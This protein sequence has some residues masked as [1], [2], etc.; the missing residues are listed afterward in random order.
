[1]DPN[2][3]WLFWGYAVG[4]LLIFGY[5]FSISQK[6]RTLR[7]KVAELQEAIDDR[8]KQKKA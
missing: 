1:M 4:W 7:K 6:E 5:L 2:L 8:W 3:G